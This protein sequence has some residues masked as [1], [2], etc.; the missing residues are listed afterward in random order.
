MEEVHRRVARFSTY[1]RNRSGGGEGRGKGDRRQED[2][3]SLESKRH[4]PFG[5]LDS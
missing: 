2:R 1:G 5:L 3:D 4:L